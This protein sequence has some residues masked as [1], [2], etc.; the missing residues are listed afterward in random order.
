MILSEIINARH[1][2]NRTVACLFRAVVGYDRKLSLAKRAV[3]ALLTTI[4]LLKQI[5]WHS[6]RFMFVLVVL[7]QRRAEYEL[8]LEFCL[9]WNWRFFDTTYNFGSANNVEA[10]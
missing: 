8:P 2:V 6:V 5:S 7:C 3:A 1:T 10:L 4:K 9:T